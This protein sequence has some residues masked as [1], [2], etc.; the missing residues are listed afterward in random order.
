MSRVAKHV[1][2]KFVAGLVAAIPIAITLFL[3][4]YVD[5]VVQKVVHL[6]YPLLGILLSLAVIYGLGVFVTSLVGRYLLRTFDRVLECIP[7][8]RD[9]YRTWKQLLVT[10]DLDSGMFAK[11]LL[12]PD[13]SGQHYWLGFSTGRPI[14]DGS[15][16]L[17][18]FVPNSPNPITGRLYFASRKR[19]H[20]LPISP[21]D[22][23]KT[24]VSSG[25]YLPEALGLPL[26]PA[27]S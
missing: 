21:K 18:V 4:F 14:G 22:A 7:G 8:L 16:R 23:I 11:V 6:P 5:S 27:S 1:K 13:E 25:N 10:P 12:L 15:D 17:C 9:L 3:V 19:C 20:F 24:V 26:P 2:N